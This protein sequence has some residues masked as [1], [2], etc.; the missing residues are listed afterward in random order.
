[1]L[2]IEH[3]AGECDHPVLRLD[4]CDVHF[5][6]CMVITS[7]SLG[8]GDFRE[9][10]YKSFAHSG[11]AERS[12]LRGEAMRRVSRR[13]RAVEVRGWLKRVF[14]I[15]HEPLS[16]GELP[17]LASFASVGGLSVSSAALAQG[18]DPD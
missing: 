10:P 4:E 2:I 17:A 8:L 18:R 1:M 13:D 11:W 5:R 3:D 14:A 15:R 7:F 12:E 6:H 9:Q 16:S